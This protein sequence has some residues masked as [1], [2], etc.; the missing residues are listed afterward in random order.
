MY[1]QSALLPG[2]GPGTTFMLA[3]A[4]NHGRA[5]ITMHRAYNKDIAGTTS[6]G[7]V[8]H[9]TDYI[10]NECKKQSGLYYVCQC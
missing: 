2:T 1:A 7:A 3:M 5:T 9:N 6:D 4:V 8:T 10:V